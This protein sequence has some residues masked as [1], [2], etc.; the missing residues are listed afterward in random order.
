[1]KVALIGC[2]N[3]AEFHVPA[4]KAV[5]FTVHSVAGSDNS[6]R[7]KSFSQ[8]HDIPN[9]YNTASE[10]INSNDWDALLI[11]SPIE[12]VPKY[13]LQAVK[14]NKPILVEKPV[15]LDPNIVKKLIKY[16]NV[17]VAYNRRYYASTKIA[18][19][20]IDEHP[21]VLLKVTIPEQ[22][23]GPNDVYQFPSRLPTLAYENSVHVIDLVN[24]LAG[25]ITWTSVSHIASSDKYLSVS[26]LGKGD[27]GINIMLDMYF[28]APANFSIDIISANERVEMR[29]IEIASYFKGMEVNEPTVDRPIRI[30]TPSLINQVVESG[31]EPN[32]KPGF[33]EQAEEFF[34]FSQGHSVEKSATLED[35]WDALNVVNSLV[36]S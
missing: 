17:L 6:T 1:M 24:Y 22:A 18:K 35:A 20:F 25:K 32:L 3:I 28:N 21:E 12:T 14:S 30:Y 11:A 34:K 23:N 5:G 8:R 4:L 15:S 31:H 33:Y 16:K 27:K 29:P 36:R 2:G 19:S 13:I 7:V 10:L 26:A 9:I